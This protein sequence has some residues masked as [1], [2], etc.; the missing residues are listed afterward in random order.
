VETKNDE[1]RTIKMTQEAYN[2]PAACIEGKQPTELPSP[3]RMD[4]P[5]A[6]FA[7]RGEAPAKRLAC[8]GCGFTIY[9]GQCVATCAA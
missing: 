1:G 5:L 3:P 6:I 8:R 7:A 9:A 2:L 4:D